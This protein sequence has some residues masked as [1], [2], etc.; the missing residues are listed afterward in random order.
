MSCIHSERCVAKKTKRTLL[1]AVELS[2]VIVLLLFGVFYLNI[3]FGGR[4][5][6]FGILPR[7]FWGVIGIFVSPLLHANQAHLAANGV[8]LFMLLTILFSHREYR[9]EVAL[10]LIWFF[11]GVGTWLIG[12]PA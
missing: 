11:S 1:D 2:A 9:G 8:S 4:L 12:R 10:A 6:N 7:T 5:N 3:F